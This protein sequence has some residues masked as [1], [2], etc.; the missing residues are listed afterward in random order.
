[1]FERG[2]GN[3]EDQIPPA[4]DTGKP[5]SHDVRSLFSSPSEKEDLP[6]PAEAKID[7]EDNIVDDDFVEHLRKHK[8]KSIFSS[9]ISDV[10]TLNSYLSILTFANA[11]RNFPGIQKLVYE[12]LKNIIYYICTLHEEV[13]KAISLEAATVGT[14]A[15]SFTSMYLMTGSALLV[16][17]MIYQALKYPCAHSKKTA[18]KAMLEELDLDSKIFSRFADISNE[19]LDKLTELIHSKIDND[20]DLVKALLSVYFEDLSDEKLKKFSATLAEHKLKAKITDNLV[21]KPSSWQKFRAN[22]EWYQTE[23][24]RYRIPIAALCAIPGVVWMILKSMDIGGD[25]TTLVT[26]D[27]S[28]VDQANTESLEI[29]P[30]MSA[31]FPVITF[32][33]TATLLYLLTR[34]PILDRLATG[35]YNK[36]HAPIE[37]WAKDSQRWVY[38][39]LGR[40]IITI[41][42]IPAIATYAGI[43]SFDF[44]ERYA[45]AVGCGTP[46]GV[47]KSIITNTPDVTGR[48][49]SSAKV[50]IAALLVG[51]T[52][53]DKFYLMYAL[54]L[55]TYYPVM[56]VIEK[57]SSLK[58]WLPR[59]KAKKV[60]DEFKKINKN[61]LY[62]AG[63]ITFVAAWVAFFIAKRFAD[64]IPQE[65]LT[66]AYDINDYIHPNMTLPTGQTNATI[67]E[68]L[69]QICPNANLTQIIIDATKNMSIPHDMTQLQAIVK[70]INLTELVNITL[71]SI[72]IK[73]INN[74]TIVATLAE[75]CPRYGVTTLFFLNLAG[76]AADCN[77]LVEYRTLA[78]FVTLFWMAISLTGG[79]SYSLATA[80]QLLGWGVKT[81]RNWWYGSAEEPEP[82]V[83]EEKVDAPVEIKIDDM[84]APLLPQADANPK[85]H[86]WSCNSI[87]NFF[88]RKPAASPQPA[89][90]VVQSDQ[91]AYIPPAVRV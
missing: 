61:S 55:V 51:D 65:G 37:K 71:P 62:I 9:V 72:P 49:T 33:I 2:T 35:Y 1:M 81:F 50:N 41:P 88:T 48:C 86:H 19:Q 52:E 79:G 36:F 57:F 68:L 21:V 5:L 27:G 87:F 25:L 20:K 60:Y 90:Q 7:V 63:S 53:F 26:D 74:S 16:L 76:I 8:I 91:S 10:F 17:L 42:A 56:A 13:I 18:F 80:G 70:S 22:T 82:V 28:V 83:E 32:Q 73:I 77:A 84:N 59:E 78:A 64:N 46:G 29:Y 45:K 66:V 47:F 85:S 4:S 23:I 38:Y 39:H 69:D 40:E 12:A 34:A 31:S 3:T 6:Q 67:P 43:K 75:A 54:L 58:E 89:P 14:E 24:A 11:A 44:I 15:T 30:W